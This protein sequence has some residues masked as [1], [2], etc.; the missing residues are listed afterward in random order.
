MAA[1]LAK[2]GHSLVVYDMSEASIQTLRDA[3]GE[4][5]VSAVSSPSEVGASSASVVVTMLPS[6]PHVQE[7]YLGES[8]V[9]A[10]AAA[11][12]SGPKFCIDASTISPP[13]AADVAA[14][15]AEAGHTLIDA[16]VSGGTIGAENATLTFMVGGAEGDFGQAKPV[17][18]RMGANIVHCG[19]PSTGQVAKVANN[20]VL[21]I[22]MI[23]V[24]EAMNLGVKSGM[25]PKVLAGIFNTSSARCWSSDTYNPCPGAMDGVPSARGF[26][27]GFGAP[28]MMKDLSLAI[29]AA[30]AV[31]APLNM[32]SNAHALYQ[33]MISNGHGDLDFSGYWEFLQPPTTGS[34][35]E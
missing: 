17:L 24:A 26:T 2:A 19:G 4:D 31:N 20:L 22:S 33:L 5:A 9:F 25:D 29:D 15:A 32:G 35:D 1:N 8:G 21:G 14:A 11:A 6:S 28:L 27:G 7:V 12:S 10:G 13:V 18:E 23:G 34:K 30:K 16:P 3:A